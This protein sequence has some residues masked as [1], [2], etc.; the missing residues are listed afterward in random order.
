MRGWAEGRAALRRRVGERVRALRAV[1]GVIAVTA[2]AGCGDSGLG[3]EPEDAEFAA[4]LGVDL[5][6][7]TKLPSGVYVQTTTPGTGTATVAFANRIT[8]GY[9]GWLADGTLFDQGT[10]QA[11][12]V[13]NFVPGFTEGVI[14]MKIGEVRKLV[15]PARLG[16]GDED[17]GQIP[18]G[19]V[20]VF[21]VTLGAIS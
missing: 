11:F 2:A 8:A 14:G 6:A 13:A 10:L 16:Y 19:S 15:I 21:E 20:L 17:Y 18:G 4:S 9:K 12:P 7:M 3:P 5:S 1:L